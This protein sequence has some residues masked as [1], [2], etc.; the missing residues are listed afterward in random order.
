MADADGDESKE[1]DG[2]EEQASGKRMHRSLP[3]VKV[4]LEDESVRANTTFFDTDDELVSRSNS[5][6]NLALP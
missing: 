4:I 3:R 5:Q 2:Q 6:L 1:N